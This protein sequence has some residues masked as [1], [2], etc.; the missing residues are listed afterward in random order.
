[1]NAFEQ[2]VAGLFRAEGYWT[3][4]GYRVDLTKQEKRETGKPSL[5]RPEIDIL[6]YRGSTNELIWIE[7]KSYLDSPGVRYSSFT[8]PEDPGFQRY[9]V[10]NDTRYREVIRTALINQTVRLKL[11]PPT[12]TL[13]YCLVAGKVYRESDKVNLQGHFSQRGWLFFDDSWLKERLKNAAE[14]QYEDDTAMVVAKII[15]RI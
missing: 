6:A 4:T 9:K 5:P 12:P 11:T 2:I 8:N 15:Q 7:C 3:I 14:S 10:F 13:S 1:M